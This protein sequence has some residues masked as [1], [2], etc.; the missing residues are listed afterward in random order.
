[1]NDNNTMLKMSVVKREY[2]RRKV[3]SL[4]GIIKIPTELQALIL[5]SK[6]KNNKFSIHV[7]RIFVRVLSVIK[8]NQV[9]NPDQLQLFSELFLMEAN[10]TVQ[11]EFKY[12][13]FCPKGYTNIN[14]IKDALAFLKNYED[15][16]W[17]KIKNHKGE[18]LEILGGLIVN[19]VINKSSDNVTFQMNA[20]WYD[21][22]LNISKHY[23]PA[24]MEFFFLTNSI[25]SIVFYN[26][27]T[28]LKPEGTA[29]KLETFNEKFSTNYKSI[30][31][32]QRSYLLPIKKELDELSD[33]S[34][35]YSKSLKNKK[36]L[37]IQQYLTNNES[38][39]LNS[40]ELDQSKI[41]RKL[42]YLRSKHNLNEN[43]LYM[44]K[45]S[46]N[47]HGYNFLNGMLLKRKKEFPSSLKGEDF[48][49]KFTNYYKKAA[50]MP[51]FE[52]KKD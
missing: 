20:F 2:K 39:S 9:K 21:K 4:P 40:K 50:S 26:Y 13:D 23:N 15:N 36:L 34:F 17:N 51:D 1:M 46:F 43:Q 3:D 29:M 28:T 31:E 25:N 44:L 22:F 37:T 24:L 18:E 52:K 7:L 12:K 8:K 10:S 49:D 38:S 19:P 45:L 35:N 32:V 11:F 6:K 27:L 48:I 41:K 5:N 16:K 33:I 14:P 47:K 30:S 42:Y